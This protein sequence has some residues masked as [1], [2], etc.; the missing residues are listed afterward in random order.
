MATFAE[1]EI[2][3]DFETGVISIA[4]AH[5]VGA[6]EANTDII[7]QNSKIAD[8]TILGIQFPELAQSEAYS[9]SLN[10]LVEA[11]GSVL[12]VRD[13]QRDEDLLSS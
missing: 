9:Q 10:D 2:V 1:A 3:S 7:A 6:L 4:Q 11:V 12:L 13:T 8:L 5:G